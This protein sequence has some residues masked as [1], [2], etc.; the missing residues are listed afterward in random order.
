MVVA[1]SVN[2]GGRMNAG[3]P[4]NRGSIGGGGRQTRLL[5]HMTVLAVTV[6]SLLAVAGAGLTQTRIPAHEIDIDGRT[7]ACTV[8]LIP[9]LTGGDAPPRLILTTSGK[10]RPGR[11]AIDLSAPA[12][13]TG[14]EFVYRNS[15]AAFV[16]VAP[17]PVDQVMRSAIWKAMVEANAR[18]LPFFLTTKAPDGRYSSAR[19]Q[20]LDPKGIL[21]ILESRCGFRASASSD[22]QL[23]ARERRLG[24]SGGQITHIRRVLNSRYGNARRAPVPAAT[25]TAPERAYLERYA[26]DAGLPQTRYLTAR[27]A[28]RLIGEKF[29]AATPDHSARPGYSAH[30]DWRTY[31][32]GSGRCVLSTPATRWTGLQPYIRPE[33]RISMDSGV[34]GNA[35]FFDLISPNPFRATAPVSAV[36][37]GR[38]YGLQQVGG[39]VRP[40][41]RGDGL[42][43]AV[44]KAFRRGRN[45]EFRGIAADSGRPALVF[46]SASGFTAAFEQAGRD[47]RRPGLRDWFR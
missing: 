36:V 45:I 10:P 27:L 17:A 9:V 32:T 42:N 2:H 23:R 22:D 21:A 47:C 31:R 5:R 33:I 29:A 13:A 4:G 26:K 28:N 24:L 16:P 46:F 3:A 37:D 30:R 43:D 19:Y 8:S 40:P 44:M 41:I 35:L 38:R 11:I 14:A 20:G 6:S 34:P 25:L 39:R 15:R 7:G 18:S 12:G 1:K